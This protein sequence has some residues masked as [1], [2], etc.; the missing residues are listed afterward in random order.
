MDL[1]RITAFSFHE[2]FQRVG[3]LFDDQARSTAL[4]DE[5]RREVPLIDSLFGLLAKT[6]AIA[7]ES[8]RHQ[9]FNRIMHDIHLLITLWQLSR[10]DEPG[11]SMRQV[12]SDASSAQRVPLR[13]R[14]AADN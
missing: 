3:E 14:R 5:A 8:D 7:E 9:V 11:N 2:Q 12:A 1:S 10:R 13:F 4:F 6:E